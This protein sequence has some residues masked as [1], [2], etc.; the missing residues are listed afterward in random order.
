MPGI[1]CTG[2]AAVG[3][4]ARL[5]E[6]DLRGGAP[7]DRVLPQV[8]TMITRDTLAYFTPRLTQAPPSS[9]STCATSRSDKD[10]WWYGHQ[11]TIRLAR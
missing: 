8:N 11:L 4:G 6:A 1:V 7:L 9:T 3:G 5:R 10:V 2:G